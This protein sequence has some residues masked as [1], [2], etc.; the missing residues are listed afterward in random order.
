MFID[1]PNTFHNLTTVIN[2]VGDDLDFGHLQKCCQ[3]T[4]WP[5][6]TLFWFYFP[7]EGNP[8]IGNSWIQ[9]SFLSLKD[10][11][12]LTLSFI[13]WIGETMTRIEDDYENTAS[14]ESFWVKVKGE[15][16]ELA[17]SFL[18]FKSSI[19]IDILLCDWLL[20]ASLK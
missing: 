14:L 12:N 19:P 1:C 3:W 17:E 16:T 11:L 20:T 4:P 15:H 18:F 5:C 10:D 8:Y 6:D 9:I 13:S 7:P 2:E